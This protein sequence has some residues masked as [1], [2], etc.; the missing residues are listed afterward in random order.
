LSW[1]LFAA[2][3]LPSDLQDQLAALQSDLKAAAPARSVRWV[4]PGGIHLTLKY[5]GDQPAAGLPALQAG[6]ARAA[7]LAEPMMLTVAGVGV[8]PNS[9]RPSVIWAGVAGAL[10][11][12]ERLQT[13]VEAE[14]LALGYQPEGRAYRPHL[15]LGRVN[16]GLTPDAA[17]GLMDGLAQA[18]GRRCGSFS[19]EHLSLMN[20]ELAAGGSV[21]HQISTAP[22]APHGRPG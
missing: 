7:A 18:R 6:L 10:A 16:E 19:P 14:A 3:E 2:L 21:Y 12:L 9:T 17:R 20:S 15:T 5:Y 4:R 11:P 1:R 13:A 8:F 22:F